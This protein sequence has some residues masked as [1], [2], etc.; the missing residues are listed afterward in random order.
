MIFVLKNEENFFFEKKN[1]IAANVA[2]CF[3]LFAVARL[4]I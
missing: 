1:L 4:T 2:T 3:L